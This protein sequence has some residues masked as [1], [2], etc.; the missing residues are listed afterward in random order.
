M[1]DQFRSIAGDHQGDD[2]AVAPPDEIDAAKTQPVDQRG[3]VDRH[4]GVAELADIRCPA[5]RPLL[6]EDEPVPWAQRR[7]EARKVVHVP[8]AAVEQHEIG[9]V[10]LDLDVHLDLARRQQGPPRLGRHDFGRSLTN[11][12]PKRPF[13]HRWPSVTDE[14]SGE[15]TFRILSS[16]TWRSSTQPTPQ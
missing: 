13:T 3:G 16:W 8:A 5:V 1:A 10:P 7:P 4:L 12:N 15:V 2:A 9:P 14:S 6:R 11:S